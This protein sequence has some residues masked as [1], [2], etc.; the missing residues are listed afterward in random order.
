MAYLLE[1]CQNRRMS[2]G[3]LLCNNCHHSTLW[4]FNRKRMSGLRNYPFSY[5]IFAILLPLMAEGAGGL[6]L[7]I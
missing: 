6:K 2:I 7:Y 3:N 1:L 4:I 5:R